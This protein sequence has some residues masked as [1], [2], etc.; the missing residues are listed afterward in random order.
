MEVKIQFSEDR[1]FANL[2]FTK[3]TKNIIALR[4]IINSLANKK[5][6]FEYNKEIIED[7]YNNFIN[8]NKSKIKIKIPHDNYID[9]SKCFDV[10]VAED[11]LSAVMNINVTKEVCGKITIPILKRVLKESGIAHGIILSKINSIEKNY[12]KKHGKEEKVTV[13]RGETEVMAQDGYLVFNDALASKVTLQRIKKENGTEKLI[14]ITAIATKRPVPKGTVLITK[15]LPVY[16]KKGMT[17]TGRPLWS[18]NNKRNVVDPRIAVSKNVEVVDNGDIWEYTALVRGIGYYINGNMIEMEELINGSFEVF[19][20]DDKMKAVISFRAPSGGE[21]I[22]SD[23]V[24]KSI[25]EKGIKVPYNKQNLINMVNDVNEN[26]IEKIDRSLFATGILPIDGTDGKVLWVVNLEMFFKPRVLPNGSVDYRGGGRFPFIRKDKI[27]GVWMVRTK[28][29]KDGSNVLG[30]PISSSPGKNLSVDWNE[31]FDF[32]DTVYNKKKSKYLV[33]K[34]SGLLNLK[35]NRVTIEPM[36]Q[37]QTIDHSTGNIDFD[38]SIVIKESIQDGFTVKC[39]KDL[40]IKGAIGACTIECGGDVFI[41]GGINGKGKGVIKAKGNVAAKF[42]ENAYIYSEKDICVKNYSLLSQLVSK[43]KVF[44]GTERAKGKIIGG[45]IYA[46]DSIL[47]HFIGSEKSV[48]DAELWLGID[49]DVNSQIKKL[50]QNISGIRHEIASLTT[51]Q[52][53]VDKKN[54][55]LIKAIQAELADKTDT[56]NELMEENNV[57]AQSLYNND[58]DSISILGQAQAH[59]QIMIGPYSQKTHEK[60]DRVVF[61]INKTKILIEKIQT[62]RR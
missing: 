29:I 1:I 54:Q 9:I 13:A 30:E 12:N 11:E 25:D 35:N 49:V 24:F 52:T 48:A 5:F 55:P 28:G 17:V 6:L 20:N 14:D 62:K 33:S 38:G 43:S 45:K 23:D 22:K 8:S 2:I 56:L 19:L 10:T 37:L 26:R 46:W 53:R 60:I 47:T 42:V 57:L 59:T 40:M 41:Q 50:E 36:V 58:C 3:E 21:K 51:K 61:K 32:K 16:G 31:C 18:G 27:A 34:S 39:T 15:V 7:E 4:A 44:I